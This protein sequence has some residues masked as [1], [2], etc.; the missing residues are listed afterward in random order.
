MNEEE[1]MPSAELVRAIQL[2]ERFADELGKNNDGLEQNVVISVKSLQGILRHL[3]LQLNG[4]NRPY[5]D[6]I[7]TWEMNSKRFTT[8]LL[9][10]ARR[11][12]SQVIAPGGQVYW[13][14]READAAEAAK[15]CPSGPDYPYDP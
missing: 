4:G 14:L 15:D 5:E 10:S 1:R 2:A 9:T 12:N 8:Q 13:L 6:V 11:G 7:Q 3:K